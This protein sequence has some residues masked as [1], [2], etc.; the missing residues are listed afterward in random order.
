MHGQ[1]WPEDAG[2]RHCA[3]YGRGAQAAG[4]SLSADYPACLHPWRH[5]RRRGHNMEELEAI[6]ARG[7]SASPINEVVIEQSVLGWKGKI[8]MEVMRDKKDNCVIVCSIENFDPMGVHTGDSI[9][10]AP[11]QT[12]T[13]AEYQKIPGRLHRHH[14]RDWR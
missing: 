3:Q 1:Y 11:V 9:T 4:T 7:L 2:Q 13:D 10:V 8:E 12:L 5:G 14:A 6:A